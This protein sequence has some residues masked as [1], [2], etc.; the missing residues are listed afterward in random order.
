MKKLA[1]F[2]LLFIS[3]SVFAYGTTEDPHQIFNISK[4]SSNEITVTI[5]ASDNVQKTCDTES[6]K[7]GYGGFKHSVEAC[8]FW[9]GRS[10]GNTC[11]IVLPKNTNFHTVGHEMRHCMQGE[12]H[13]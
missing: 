4:V 8:S 3:T 5:I 7:R 11:T 2:A 13:K 12:F 9:S 6:K 1:I 10:F